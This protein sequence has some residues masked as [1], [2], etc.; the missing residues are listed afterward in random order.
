MIGGKSTRKNAVG[1]KTC[2]RFQFIIF[3]SSDNTLSS[4]PMS[5]PK[6]TTTMDSG[7][8]WKPVIE[9][10]KLLNELNWNYSSTN[11]F[12]YLPVSNIVWIRRIPNAIT[13]NTKKMAMEL[14]CSCSTAFDSLVFVTASV[15][16]TSPSLF[17]ASTGA[18]GATEDDG[19][20]NWLPF[21]LVSLWLDLAVVDELGLSWSD[22]VDWVEFNAGV[23]ATGTLADDDFW[24]WATSHR[25][26]SIRQ[27]A[28]T[29]KITDN[30]TLD[31]RMALIW[32]GQF[33]CAISNICSRKNH[34]FIA[35]TLINFVQIRRQLNELWF[36]RT[37]SMRI[38][39]EIVP[40]QLTRQILCHTGKFRHFFTPNLAVKCIQ[41]IHKKKTT[42]KW[43]KCQNHD[44]LNCV[45]V[46]CWF[47]VWLRSI[48]PCWRNIIW[49]LKFN[50]K[51]RFD[52]KSLLQ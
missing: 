51:P 23:T 41:C 35:R 49:L 36:F 39:L 38:S 27:F 31:T 12:K 13:H 18:S 17:S 34:Y 25:T 15:L 20:F 43:L 14:L 47:P 8:Y 5:A 45:S 30:T 9:K 19:F 6:K 33:L 22:G 21:W 11:F 46:V 29:I 42:I 40:Q 10:S 7:K 24:L 2:S 3:F 16:L 32:F 52:W 1:E 44:I 50:L 4:N 48:P 37:I 28:R 26:L